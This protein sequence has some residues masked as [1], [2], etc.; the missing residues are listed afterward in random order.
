MVESYVI[1]VAQLYLQK[2]FQCFVLSYQIANIRDH[3]IT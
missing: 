1:M 2:D 3:D